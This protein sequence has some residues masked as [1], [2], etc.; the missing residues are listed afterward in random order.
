MKSLG[1]FFGVHEQV[2]AVQLIDVDGFD[3]EAFERAVA[4]LENMLGRKII[5]VGRVGMRVAP[6]DDAALGRNRDVLIEEIGA[7][8]PTNI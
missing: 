4:G 1:N 8:G 3:T 6:E 2:G 5:A 7:I